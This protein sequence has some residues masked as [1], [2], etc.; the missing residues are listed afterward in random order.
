MSAPRARASPHCTTCSPACRTPPIVTAGMQPPGSVPTSPPDMVGY[1]ARRTPF[2]RHTGARSGES[3]SS[4]LGGSLMKPFRKNARRIAAGVAVVGA[5]MLAPAI[6][7]AS[8]GS[9]ARPDAKTITPACETP[10]L[11]VWLDTSGNG[12]AGTI[13]YKLHFTNLSGHACT[14]NG[15]PFLFAINL[16][17]HQVGPR[18]VF[19]K[20]SPHCVTLGKGKTVTAVLG[21]VDSRRLLAVGL[22][23]CHC[24]WPSRLPA[25]PDEVQGG[26]VP[27]QYLLP[28]ARAGLAQRGSG[29]QVAVASYCQD[30]WIKI[31]KQRLARPC[32]RVARRA[33]R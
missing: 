13:F 10:G 7:L 19:R 24:C 3:R 20:P 17:G 15:Y 21:I 1:L 18:A 12:A 26:P 29:H 30:L 32:R 9:P 8:P 11:V 22:P 23:A 28:C 31:F 27:V 33:C 25:K 4:Q 2:T 14:L 5:L 16:K 6:A